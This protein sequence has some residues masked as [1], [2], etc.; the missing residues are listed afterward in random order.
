MSSQKFVLRYTTHYAENIMIYSHGN[1]KTCM[2]MAIC[3]IKAEKWNMPFLIWHLISPS[4]VTRSYGDFRKKNSQVCVSMKGKTHSVS[5]WQLF[6]FVYLDWLK[7]KHVIP[8]VLTKRISMYPCEIEY[9]YWESVQASVVK[10]EREHK[11]FQ[12]NLYQ[13]FKN[14]FMNG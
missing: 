9:K 14:Y 2:N 12:V 6:G 11:R 4:S 13:R 7:W 3:Q 8:H 10:R 5:T 1:W